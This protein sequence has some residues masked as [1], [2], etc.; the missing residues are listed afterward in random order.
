VTPA[1]TPSIPHAAD[2]EPLA[3]LVE[4]LRALDFT[5]SGCAVRLG[6][7]PLLGIQFH[8]VSAGRFGHIVRS[9]A[10]PE[11]PDELRWSSSDD[12]CDLLI[13]LFLASEPVALASLERALAPPKIETLVA[14]GLIQVVGSVASSDLNLFPIGDLV[15][16]TDR[17]GLQLGINPVSALYP[18]TYILSS[19]IDRSQRHPRTLDLCTGSGVHALLAGSHS[20]HVLAVDINP[21][22]IAFAR[23]NQA[24]NDLPPTVTFAEG[25]LYDPCPLDTRYDLIVSNP[26]YVP[27][28]QHSSSSNWF[29]GGPSGD[30]LLSRILA[31]LDAHLTE[32]GIAHLYTLFV[33][34]PDV[35]YRDK[36]ATWLGDISRWHVTIRAVPF[37]FTSA[38]A[39]DP[40][41]ERYE[42]G[43]IEVRRCGEGEEARYVEELGLGVKAYGPTST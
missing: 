4:A 23:F 38:E 32:D 41:P 10:G 33:H 29:S 3:A 28:V 14:T 30:D 15:L 21:R 31:G 17:P 1:P 11:M 19:A 2:P 22:A 35:L 5:E 27:S 7:D 39:L 26:P 12:P 6:L 18:E 40:T 20:D 25:D 16:A 8:H 43:M 9:A 36:I 13:G 24:L 37:P 34:H 42:L